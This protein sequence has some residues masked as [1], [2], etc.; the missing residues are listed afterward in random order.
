MTFAQPDTRTLDLCSW[1]LHEYRVCFVQL[2]LIALQHVHISGLVFR[3]GNLMEGQLC[4]E[5]N[6]GLHHS[7]QHAVS[8]QGIYWDKDTQT[9]SEFA[10]S[11]EATQVPPQHQ[12]FIG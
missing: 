7:V 9:E 2:Q 10:Q 5:S 8:H 11:W 1:M 4:P 6:N 12:E 3:S